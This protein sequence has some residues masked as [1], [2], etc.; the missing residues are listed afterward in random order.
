MELSHYVYSSCVDLR[1]SCCSVIVTTEIWITGKASGYYRH[2]F[3]HRVRLR[4]SYDPWNR[5][6]W[7]EV[8]A[9][10][11]MKSTVPQVDVY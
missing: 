11:A 2:H 5:V 1:A 8:L 3:A 6:A 9:A 10:V 7:I 4:V